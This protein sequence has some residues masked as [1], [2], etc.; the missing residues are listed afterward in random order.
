M[1]FFTGLIGYS[2]AIAAQYY[3][4][5]RKDLSAVTA[6]QAIIIS[7]AAYP[8]I[9]GLI[10]AAEN[11]F[12]LV[13]T[14]CNQIGHQIEYF[15]I[16]CYGAFPS[17]IRHAMGCYFTGIGRTRIVMTATFAALTINIS[18]GYMLIFGKSGMPAMGIKGA[19]V[20]A[21]AASVSAVI[22]L[23]VAYFR[24]SHCMEF[25]VMSSFHFNKTV[26]KKLL[27]FGYPAGIEL[28]LYFFAF[29]LMIYI[30]QSQGDVVATASSIM[31]NWDMAA[32]VP[33][34]GIEIAVTSLVGRYMGAGNP[35]LAHQSAMS[36]VHTGLLYAFS[37]TCFFLFFPEPLVNIFRPETY[38]HVFESAAPIAVSMVRIAS[39][40]IIAETVMVALIGALRG[41]GDTLWVMT[42]SVTYQWL[43][44]PVLYLMLNIMKFSPVTAWSGFVTL[45]MVFCA[46]L[47]T[48]YR[49]GKWRM[50]KIV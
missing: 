20:A 15:E 42:A 21:I 9:V 8:V 4:S 49:R 33:L 27:Y 19:A 38:N 32:F 1:F 50:L 2:T 11:F 44:I 25:K 35:E 5:G 16:I 13:G 39:I 22:I 24:R 3:G 17:M 48:R 41:A 36:G 46:V 43:F 45:F 23:G 10:P 28:F 34:L 7:L 29:T 40:Y 6:F 30:F 31:F 12:Y 26:M 47:V 18:L 37:V 14:P